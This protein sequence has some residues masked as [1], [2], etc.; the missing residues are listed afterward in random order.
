MAWISKEIESL[1]NFRIA[2]EEK[3]Y[4]IYLGMAEWLENQG[5]S[6]AAKLWKKYSE[7]EKK[8]SEIVREY[9]RDLDLQP[10]LR[11]ILDVKQEFSSLEQIIRDSFTHE[12]LITD[13]CNELTKKAMEANDFMTM[14]LGMFFVKEQREEIQKITYL[15]NRLELF[16]T[17][18]VALR[19]LDE[20]MNELAE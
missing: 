13:Q 6:G 11:P 10:E 2:E 20:E 3:S 16:G 15:I 5:Y 7:E 8:H 4:R 18:E 14:E 12:M 17:S 1:L 19:M 9:I